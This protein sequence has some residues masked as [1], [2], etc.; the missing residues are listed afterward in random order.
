MGVIV[1]FASSKRNTPSNKEENS[2]GGNATDA[3]TAAIDKE[4]YPDLNAEPEVYWLVE[5]MKEFRSQL[6]QSFDEMLEA[7]NRFCALRVLVYTAP[8]EDFKA[9][10][11]VTAH[12][13]VELIRDA[14]RELDAVISNPSVRIEFEE[15]KTEID[16]WL[17]NE[18]YNI[19]M[20]V[21]TRLQD[22]V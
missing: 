6:P 5:C 19:S 9:S 20:H 13:H 18:L 21:Q 7:L 10:W 14:I 2:D 8:K 3:T 12:H 17:V 16:G 4:R 22:D 15:R 11:S 1:Q